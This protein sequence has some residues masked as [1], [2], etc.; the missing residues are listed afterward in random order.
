MPGH[1]ATRAAQNTEF[2]RR[3]PSALTPA[4]AVIAVGRKPKVDG[5]D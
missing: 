2:G 4:C 5:D 1:D 3:R